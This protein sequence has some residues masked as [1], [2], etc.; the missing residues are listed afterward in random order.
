M[1]F[2]FVVS[3]NCLWL[4]L[5]NRIGKIFDYKMGKRVNLAIKKAFERNHLELERLSSRCLPFLL[6]DW[7][8]SIIKRG[9]GEATDKTKRQFLTTM[10][11][12]SRRK[13]ESEHVPVVTVRK[14]YRLL[15]LHFCSGL[16]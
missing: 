6:C 16:L 14:N 2:R 8:I 7:L 11:L 4:A 1:V 15:I 9:D 13:E 3:P 5:S 10:K 12:G